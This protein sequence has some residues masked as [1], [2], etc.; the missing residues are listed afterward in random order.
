MADIIRFEPMSDSLDQ[1][2]TD[3]CGDLQRAVV[4]RHHE[5][6]QLY[7]SS[8]G[9]T[10][11]QVRTV[12]FRKFFYRE[13]RIQF[14]T[15]QRSSKVAEI[16]KNPH[17]SLLGYSRKSDIQIRFRGQARKVETPQVLVEKWNQVGLSS[18]RCYLS[19]KAPGTVSD[20]PTSG[21]PAEFETRSPS[22][23]E[24]EL[25]FSHFALIEFEI[26][27]LEWL[28]LSSTGH[29]RAL[30]TKSGTRSWLVP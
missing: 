14:H 12:I 4:D 5:M 2:W 30:F 6:H 28:K 13:L 9:E 22:E 17:S 26:Q 29:R 23:E 1:L 18:R 21:L 16:L 19:S 7:F 24:S 20:H 15:D 27:E 11:P 25:G 10:Y 3:I 8:F